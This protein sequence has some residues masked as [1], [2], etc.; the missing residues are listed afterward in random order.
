MMFGRH[1]NG[2]AGRPLS[3]HRH[4][5]AGNPVIGL[6][7]YLRTSA[8][9]AGD[10]L[11]KWEDRIQMGALGTLLAGP[12]GAA[13]IHLDWLPITVIGEC[14]AV[15]RAILTL[16]TGWDYLTLACATPRSPRGCGMP[17]AA[18]YYE[19]AWPRRLVR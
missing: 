11:A 14:D 15:D 3:R 19:A 9:A 1:P 6:R 2:S 4:H 7:E 17:R 18:R 12:S 8:S 10:K 5:A 13:L 16:V